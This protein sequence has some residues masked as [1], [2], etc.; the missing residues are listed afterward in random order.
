[1]LSIAAIERVVKKTAAA[2][3]VKS[4]RLFGSYADGNATEA[5]D[6]DVMVEFGRRPVTLLDY[7]GFQQELSE[8]LHTPVDVIVYPLSES[9]S[10]SMEF[11]R[12]IPLYEKQG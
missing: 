11:G 3:P 5:S 12:I 8:G 4:V 6:V 2:Y 10:A 7:C 9:A 1:M